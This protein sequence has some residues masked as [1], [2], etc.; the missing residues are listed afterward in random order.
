L[1]RLAAE[2]AAGTSELRHTTVADPDT[3]EQVLL[4]VALHGTAS[5]VETVVRA[6]RRRHTPPEDLAARRSLS[7]RWDEDGSLVL[8][9]RFTPE[10]GA[11]LVAAIEALLPAGSITA[12]GSEGCPAG[13]SSRSP[14]TPRSR[15]WRSR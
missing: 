7:W 15:P 5:H 9:G 13:G 6:V 3:A 12:T 1:N 8:R 2:I 14:T 4:N 10:D 11:A